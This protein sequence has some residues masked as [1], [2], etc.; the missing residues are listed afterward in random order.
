M[1]HRLAG[2]AALAIAPTLALPA[3]RQNASGFDDAMDS[4]VYISVMGELADLHRYSLAG[5]D[6]EDRQARADSARKVILDSHSVTA[7]QLLAFAKSAGSDPTRMETLADLITVSA[8]SLAAMRDTIVAATP[9]TVSD[10]KTDAPVGF[11]V[12]GAATPQ[13]SPLRTRLDSLRE[14]RGRLPR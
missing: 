8:D 11:R 6:G 2:L 3:C 12:H 7:E 10:T 14:A 13:P 4:E 9:D 1:K 5:S